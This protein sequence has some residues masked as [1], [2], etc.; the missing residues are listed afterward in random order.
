MQRREFLAVIGGAIGAAALA[1]SPERSSGPRGAFAKSVAALERDARGRLGVTVLDTATG[2]RF[3]WRQ[4][5]RFAMCSTFKLPLAA[6]MLMEADA[7][8][9]RLDQPVPVPMELPPYSPFAG[10][11]RGGAATIAELCEAATTLSDNGAANVLLT[12]IDGPAGFTSR[13]RGLGDRATRLDRIEP[14]MNAVGPGDPRDTTTP[15]AMAELIRRLALGQ[16]LSDRART[17]L[18]DWMIATKTGARRLRAGLPAGWR[19]GDKTGT[20]GDG[21]FNDVAVIWPPD[22]APL[23]VT[24]Y[25]AE[26]S[27]PGREADAIHARL[28]ALIAASFA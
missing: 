14:E 20:S 6:L 17:Q 7:G 2:A 27:L 18:V 5:E 19:A 1:R 10:T 22:R 12:L 4:A 16:I 21:H 11:R 8:R 28:G 24:A 23:V 25:L 26:T 9:L 3:G 15:Q 13:L